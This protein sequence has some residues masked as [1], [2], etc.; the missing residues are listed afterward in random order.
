MAAHYNDPSCGGAH[1]V[2]QHMTGCGISIQDTVS[3]NASEGF[4]GYSGWTSGIERPAPESGTRGHTVVSIFEKQVD[5]YPLPGRFPLVKRRD[6]TADGRETVTY[7]LEL[8][9]DQY[10]RLRLR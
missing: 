7:Y 9:W 10:E 5:T 4:R 8:T 1:P 3:A 2:G 6:I